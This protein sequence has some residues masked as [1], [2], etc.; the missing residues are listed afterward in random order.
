MLFFSIHLSQSHPNYSLMGQKVGKSRSCG[1]TYPYLRMPSRY[2]YAIGRE[3]EI[4]ENDDNLLIR[5]CANPLP[6][7]TPKCEGCDSNARR[8][9]SPDLKSGPFGLA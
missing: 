1:Y 5:I 4:E 6:N 3:Y 7:Y 9:A 2:A 8:P